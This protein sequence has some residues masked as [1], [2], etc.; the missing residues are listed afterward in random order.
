M[1]GLL[2]ILGAGAGVAAR[3]VRRAAAEGRTNLA[4]VATQWCMAALTAPVAVVCV[5]G[6]L[7]FGCAITS[8]ERTQCAVAMRRL[9]GACLVYSMDW[10]EKLPPVERW[11][12]RISE[13]I[14]GRGASAAR[15]DEERAEDRCHATTAPW[16][17]GLNHAIGGAASTGGQPQE[18]VLLFEADAR[19]S[20]PSGGMAQVAR[21]RH[22]AS[23]TIAFLDGRA[24]L[25]PDDAL[26]ALTWRIAAE[27]P[28]SGA[29]PSARRAR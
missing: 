11:R 10:D 19:D 28:T 2:V 7:H 24:R 18:T 16:T 22:G 29:R 26:A 8:G 12:E 4:A 17:Y 5:L 25:V 14:I 21:S 13:R 23:S 27:P 6:F 3:K 9:A 15:R 20:S 1:L